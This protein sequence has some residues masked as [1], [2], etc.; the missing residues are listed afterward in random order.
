MKLTL[1][2][3]VKVDNFAN[4]FRNL[5]NILDDVNITFA[6]THMYIQGMDPTHALLAEIKIQSDWFDEYN[7][8][9]DIVC[10]IHCETL[11]KVI[12]CL[13]DGQGISMEIDSDGDTLNISFEGENSFLKEYELS[14]IDLDVEEQTVPDVEWS[15][16]I[17]IKSSEF[18]ELVKELSIFEE[19][20]SIKC[21]D[22]NIQLKASG[23]LGSMQVEI[24]QEDI[25]SYS[26]E[27]DVCL[28]LNFS[29]SFLDKACAFSKLHPDMY[30][31]CDS[32]YPMKI[33]YPLDEDG[34]SFCRFLIAPKFD[35]D[36]M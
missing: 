8:D 13:S 7:T 15:A 33:H 16:D 24:K 18:S 3:K 22:S 31:H 5:K 11:F 34:E 36:E 4:I 14:I 10:G 19:N 12:N 30:I 35:I 28:K 20:V 25:I 29:L 26:I 23:T 1:K 32:Q 17:C 21:D 27:E 9:Q 6:D 2:D